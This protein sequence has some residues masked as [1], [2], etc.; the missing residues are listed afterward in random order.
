VSDSPDLVVV[1]AGVMGSWAALRAIE[2]GRR[3]LLLDGYGPGDPRATS[4]AESRISRASHGRDRLYPQWS[5]QARLDWIALDEAA[6]EP[7]FVPAGVAWFAH[8]EGGFE[9]DSEAVLRD[10]G[11]PVERLTPAE[12]S[13]RWPV[14]TGDLAFVIHEPEAGILRARAGVRAVVR[15][16]EAGGGRSL[17]TRVTPGKRRGTR[18]L[19]VVAEDGGRQAGEAFVFA[20]GPWLPGLFPELV[21]ETI[22]V[23]RQDVVYVGPAA[24][25]DRFDAAR[26]PAWVDF[27]AE[28]YGIPA[29]DGRA[30]KVAPDGYGPRFDPDA[31]E[32]LVG[33]GSIER[34]RAFVER[35][36]PALASGPVV[37][38]RVCQYE[39]TPDTHFVIDRHPDLENVWIVGG[40]SGHGFKHGPRIGRYVVDRLDG[41]TDAE[42]D[43]RFSITR[44]RPPTPGY[45][46]GASLP[47]TR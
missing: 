9:S 43:W 2:G 17:R 39:S 21:G 32:R 19:D 11:V 35:R 6:G 44:P 41:L 18:L 24:G 12:A 47:P 37:E 42:V 30:F 40:G 46:S 26:F 4:G 13:R 29:L 27:E 28:V 23:T 16:F 33:P 31:G 5:R 22:S 25:D 7:I 45:R 34:V 3:T 15:A 20:A 14:A 38:T 8:R 1:G 10:L 36:F